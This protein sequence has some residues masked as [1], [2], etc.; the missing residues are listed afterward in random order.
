MNIE[1]FLESLSDPE[2]PPDHAPLL[3][4]LWHER[5]GDWNRAHEIAQD[6][7]DADGAWVH[8]YLHRRE[9]DRANAGYWYRQARKPVEAGDLDRE[10]RAI[11]D[12]LLGAPQ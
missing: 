1:R 12:A 7:A 9:G 3:L 5:R 2:P 10:W 4:A 8:A 11:V 6:V